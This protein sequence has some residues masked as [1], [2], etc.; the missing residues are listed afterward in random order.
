MR[1]RRFLSASGAIF[2]EQDIYLFREG[3]HA[4]LYSLL[5]AHRA[6]EAGQTGFQFAVWAPNAKFVSVTGDFNDWQAKR[7]PLRCRDDNSGIWQGFVKGAKAGDSYKFHI[8]GANGFVAEKADP[9]AIHTEEPPRS[10]SRLWTLEYNWEDADWMAGRHAANALDAPMSVYE[11]H[12]G[13]WRRAPE[14]GNRHL[15]GL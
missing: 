11:V 3:S 6:E 10:A 8:E 2:S 14:E 7:H 4:R 1:G 5:G 13:S 12:L 9:F 15:S